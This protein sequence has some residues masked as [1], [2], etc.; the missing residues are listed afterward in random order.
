MKTGTDPNAN[1]TS[2]STC[3]ASPTTFTSTPTAQAHANQAPSFH[4]N[5]ATTTSLQSTSISAI[6]TF[7]NEPSSVSQGSVSSPCFHPTLL[8]TSR[9]PATSA[10]TR[11]NGSFRGRQRRPS[12]KT[13]EILET[14]YLKTSILAFQSTYDIQHD[15]PRPEYQ[16]SIICSQPFLPVIVV[17]TNHSIVLIS[18]L[19]EVKQTFGARFYNPFST[20]VAFLVLTSHAMKLL[21]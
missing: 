14:H 12:P 7:E 10:S 15:L 1:S 11:P 6:F 17:D 3:N 16:F 13:R 8:P 2:T 21:S 19:I 20:T 9:P 18:D 4:I 5:S